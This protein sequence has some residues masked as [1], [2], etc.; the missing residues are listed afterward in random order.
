MRVVIF[1]TDRNILKPGTAVYK[2]QQAYAEYFESYVVL[3]FSRRRHGLT[4]ISLGES[5][6]AYPASM[7]TVIREA[8]LADIISTQDPFETGFVAWVCSFIF[9]KAL[10]VQV[11]PEVFGPGYKAHHFL[12]RIR[13][14]V[15]AFVLR[16]AS[17]IRVVSEGI[18]EALQ[19]Q[20]IKTP[21]T[22]L[23]IFVD[24]HSFEKIPR[25]KHPQFKISLLAIGRLES[26]K[27]FSLCIRALK[28][29]RNAHHDAG[30]TIIGTGS[31]KERLVREAKDAGLER[32][33]LLVGEQPNIKYFLA[34]AD[35]VLVSSRYEGYGMVTIEA[36]AAGIPVLSTPVGVG[37]EAGAMIAH[38]EE[39]ADAALRWIESGSRQ[40][41]LKNYPYADFDE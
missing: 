21:S 3:V 17:H 35:L 28:T 10:H 22:V 33:V 19:R 7:R 38:E 9:K 41:T 6:H 31:L 4:A 34:Q 8:R 37:Q 24:V 39:F 5:A 14:L 2:R 15:A 29:I 12:N 20:G 16:R 27:Q 26:E 23:P 36:L 32:F 40:A 11:H 25:L 18:R 13:R 1:S 30:L